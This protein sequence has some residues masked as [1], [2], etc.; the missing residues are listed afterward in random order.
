MNNKLK[1]V[2]ATVAELLNKENI[3]WALGASSV[4]YHHQLAEVV[5]DLDI[6]VHPNSLEKLEQ[7]LLSL[8]SK[9]ETAP[10][11]TYSN[12]YFGE[13][14]IDGIELDV[15]CEMVINNHGASYSYD[16]NSDSVVDYMTV[17]GVEVPMSSLEEWYILYQMIPNRD[18]KVKIIEAYFENN[19]SQHPELLNK[20]S[21]LPD[22]IIK[23]V[24][25]LL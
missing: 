19:I 2:L 4:L 16:F 24:E 9:A 23:K 25:K 22:F 20:T 5:N 17:N 12:D 15:M 10:S 3:V 6:V 7:I 14:I 8:G 11:D 21:G 18:K 1:T 13:F